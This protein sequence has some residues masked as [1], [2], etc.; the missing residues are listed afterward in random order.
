MAMNEKPEDNVILYTFFSPGIDL[1]NEESIPLL[2][3][4]PGQEETTRELQRI[5]GWP[6]CFFGLMDL[7]DF[8]SGAFEVS[9]LNGTVA[10][11]LSVPASEIRWAAFSLYHMGE[12]PKEKT[13]FWDPETIRA[14]PDIPAG[15]VKFPVKPEWVLRTAYPGRNL[16]AGRAWA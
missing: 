7:E 14:L 13:F 1:T 8:T 3:A 5:L 15:F 10:W 4:N 9:Y 2:M 11:I 16:L 12:V 6:F